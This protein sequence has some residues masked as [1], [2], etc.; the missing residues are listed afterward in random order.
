[1]NLSSNFNY[2]QIKNN[3]INLYNQ[4]R[5]D[6]DKI[7]SECVYNI[8]LCYK[9]K[10]C[11]YCKLLD[12]ICKLYASVAGPIT[13]LNKIQLCNVLYTDIKQTDI[14][15]FFNNNENYNLYINNIY[16]MFYNSYISTY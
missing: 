4:Y 1:M 11:V 14:I 10:N 7:I 2:T 8:K 6:Y 9:C 3:Y 12:H 13:I 15:K 5:K 16:E